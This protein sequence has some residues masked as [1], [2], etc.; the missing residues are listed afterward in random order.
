VVS[1]YSIARGEKSPTVQT[2]AGVQSHANSPHDRL[3]FWPYYYYYSYIGY[4][5]YYC[6]YCYYCCH[7]FSG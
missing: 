7:Y 5:Y 2:K 4:Y 1:S 6:Y 3:S